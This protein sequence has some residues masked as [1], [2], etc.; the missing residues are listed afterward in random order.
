MWIARAAN[1]LPAP[2]SSISK[3]AASVFPTLATLL[4]IFW[5]EAL[6]PI[7]CWLE[8]SLLARES[9]RTSS[10]KKVKLYWWSWTGRIF[11][12]LGSFLGV[13]CMWSTRSLC[14]DCLAAPQRQS[15]P[16]WS[17][18]SHSGLTFHSTARFGRKLSNPWPVSV[19]VNGFEKDDSALAGFGPYFGSTF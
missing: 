19:V 14:P 10:T 7:N 11:A 2:D 3:T 4:N 12:S 13:W 16:A 6:S 18:G 5:K 1:S 8:G 15:S 9:R 17:Q